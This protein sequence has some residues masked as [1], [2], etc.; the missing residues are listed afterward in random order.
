MTHVARCFREL[1]KWGFIEVIEERNGG[2]R[3]GGVERIYRSHQRPHFDAPTWRA[4]P[5]LVRCEIS[6]FF[7][8]NYFGRIADAIKAGTFDGDTDRHLSWKPIVVDRPAWTAISEALDEVLEWLP[9]L[10]AQ[11]LERTEDVETLIPT[12][13]GLASFRSPG[14]AQTF[15]D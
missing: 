7:L 2:R 6:D 9:E 3:G 11:S 12:T 5:Q 1:A 10:E 13:V 15:A 4:L 14:K 8:T